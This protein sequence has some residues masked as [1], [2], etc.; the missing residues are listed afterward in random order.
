MATQVVKIL[1]P[2]PL[3]RVRAKVQPDRGQRDF[4]RPGS[5]ASPEPRYDIMLAE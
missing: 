2:K 3:R 4:Y 5:D 1:T